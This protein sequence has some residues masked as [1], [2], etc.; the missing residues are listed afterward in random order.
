[1]IQENPGAR[2]VLDGPG[3][4]RRPMAFHAALPAYAPTPLRDADALAEELGLG[5]L[6]LK[7]ESSRLGLPAFKIVGASW[8][9]AYALRT[10]LGLPEAAAAGIDA[11]RDALADGPRPTLVAATDG[12]H[13]RAV[14][15]MA[16]LL[17]LPARIYVPADMVEARR[18]AIRGEGAEVVVVDGSYD[19]AVAR[20]GRDED[21]EHVVV[22][23]TSWPGYHDVPA[24]VID[25]YSTVLWEV[26]DALRARG[27]DDPDVVLVQVGV[28]AFAAAVAR[29]YRRPGLE[30][31]PRLIAMEP[32][33][34]A[35]VLASIRAGRQI[36][37]PGVQDSIMAGLNCA[38][39]SGIAWPAV[40]GG[41]DTFVAV[42]DDVAREG[43]RELARAGIVG[44]EC[45]GGA[46]GTIRALREAG[47][48][49]D[50]ATVLTFLT[51]GATDPAGYVEIVGRTPEEVA[52]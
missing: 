27:Q 26:D 35:C 50:G 14:A 52:G 45:A 3:P 5:A 28:G 6:W 43:M 15:R 25:G 51:E 32:T 39:P 9:V 22:S 2:A 20:S 10:R 40:A 48:L 30:R 36:T 11:L 34:A 8:A 18:E 21:S 47:Q 49:A 1:M 31:P 23:D 12:N 44:G 4:D 42:D 46:V 41:I 17:G 19:D 33:R 38:T 37:I 7:D 13:G 24:A 29:H 16:A